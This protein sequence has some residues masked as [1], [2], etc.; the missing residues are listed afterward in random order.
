MHHLAGKSVLVLAKHPSFSEMRQRF[1]QAVC[2][3]FAVWNL[4]D[5]TLYTNLL[6]RSFNDTW[7]G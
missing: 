6:Y 7:C 3:S 1:L 4:M 2:Y 5:Y